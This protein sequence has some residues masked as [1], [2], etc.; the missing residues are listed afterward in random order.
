MSYHF[1]NLYVILT[2]LGLPEICYA[3]NNIML[4]YF[5]A[6]SALGLVWNHDIF[7]RFMSH[8][9]YISN[10][11]WVFLRGA[12]NTSA[13]PDDTQMYRSAVH[14]FQV[15]VIQEFMTR[16]YMWFYQKAHSISYDLNSLLIFSWPSGKHTTPENLKNI[17][18][19][20]SII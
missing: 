19:Y 2:S 4:Y 17:L 5:W 14:N 9:L 1:R 8:F 11:L 16:I 18:S 3:P 13:L 7:L 12:I 15:R 10:Y 6:K 20:A